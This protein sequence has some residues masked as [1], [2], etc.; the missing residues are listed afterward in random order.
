MCHRI[1]ETT[2]VGKRR[3]LEVLRFVEAATLCDAVS[4]RGR[5]DDLY[6]HLAK[7][8]LLPK[9]FLILKGVVSVQ[10][11]PLSAPLSLQALSAASLGLRSQVRQAFSILNVYSSAQVIPSDS[12]LGNINGRYA[13]ESPGSFQYTGQRLKDIP[14]D[15]ATRPVLSCAG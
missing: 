8:F 9:D 14:Q 10:S 6:G 2:L 3:P 12:F 1:L 11:L 13:F 5:V 7:M 15:E 4:R